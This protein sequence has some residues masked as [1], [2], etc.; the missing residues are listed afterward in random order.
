MVTSEAPT[1]TADPLEAMAA[2]RSETALRL[3]MLLAENARFAELEGLSMSDQDSLEGSLLKNPLNTERALA[4]LGLM[5]GA[6]PTTAILIKLIA[7][8]E[9]FDRF[10]LVSM[11]AVF[12][13][14]ATSVAG[15]F[16]GK[17]VGRILSDLERKPWIVMLAALPFL[18]TVWGLLSG[19]AGGFILF[20]F[21]AVFGGAIG[22]LVGAAVLVAFG[23]LHR[24]LKKGDNMESNHFIPVALGIT[25][26]VAAFILGF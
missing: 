16:S 22:A 5:T 7:N 13:I 24:L 26:S 17:L 15:F 2:N 21:G 11:I 4:I 3:E 18:G 14:A 25:V 9:G 20:G 23:I 12:S 19:A 10:A 8:A 1:H 6:I